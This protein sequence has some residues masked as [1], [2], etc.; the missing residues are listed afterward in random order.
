MCV[1]APTVIIIAITLQQN[2]C[3][4]IRGKYHV[5][6]SPNCDQD[7]YVMRGND[8]YREEICQCNSSKYNRHSNRPCVQNA[9]CPIRIER[10]IISKRRL[11]C[12]IDTVSSTK[13]QRNVR[14]CIIGD[15]DT[16]A[17]RGASNLAPQ[18]GVGL[19]SEWSADADIDNCYR[20]F[21]HG[22]LMKESIDYSRTRIIGGRNG[23]LY[24]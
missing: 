8:H 7:R 1:T 11:A 13:E 18:Q 5:F 15:T 19:R 6:P 9:V 4:R 17:G 16:D 10:I 24:S 20:A 23:A 12:T 3:E 21:I 22:T 2:G 14:H